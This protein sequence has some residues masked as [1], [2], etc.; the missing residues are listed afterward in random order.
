MD[1]VRYDLS[2]E[3]IGY[4][5][6]NLLEHWVPSTFRSPNVLSQNIVYYFWYKKNLD[7]QN[8][9]ILTNA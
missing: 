8:A 2:Y 3:K 4:Y 1:S 5:A 6:Y 7:V 9:V